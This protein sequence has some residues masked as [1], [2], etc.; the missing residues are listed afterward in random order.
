MRVCAAKATHQDYGTSKPYCLGWAG[1]STSCMGVIARASMW[2]K[3][4]VSNGGGFQTH[5]QDAFGR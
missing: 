3:L 2:D 5:L 4:R 1:S